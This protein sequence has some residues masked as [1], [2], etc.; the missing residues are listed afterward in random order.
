LRAVR[1]DSIEVATT[2][3]SAIRAGIAEVAGAYIW[4]HTRTIHAAVLTDRH[5]RICRRSFK[6]IRNY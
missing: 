2:V 1:A 4:S 5:T 3:D 6:R